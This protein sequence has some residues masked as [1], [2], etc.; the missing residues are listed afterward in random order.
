MYKLIVLG[1]LIAQIMLI[2]YSNLRNSSDKNSKTAVSLLG[3]A[4]GFTGVLAVV[5]V[6]LM[7]PRLMPYAP[8]VLNVNIHPKLLFGLLAI[9]LFVGDLLWAGS[10][11]PHNNASFGLSVALA[12]AIVVGLFRKH[13]KDKEL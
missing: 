6:M 1:L 8:D 3:L 12:V 4:A 2:S 13:L 11:T 9:L 7:V 5:L 10:S